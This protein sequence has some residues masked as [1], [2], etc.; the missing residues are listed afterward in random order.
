MTTIRL[1]LAKCT[2][3]LVTAA[4]LAASSAA[5]A[6]EPGWV[7]RVSGAW[8]DPDFS[9]R[10]VDEEQEVRLD[11]DSEIGFAVDVEYRFSNRLGIDVGVTWV[12]LDTTLTVGIPDVISLSFDDDLSFTPITAALNIYLTPSSAVDLYIAPMIAWVQYGDLE[13]ELEG[14]G[15][16]GVAIDDDLAWGAAVGLDVPIGERG[17][18]VSAAASYIDTDLD[19]TEQDEGGRESF[20]FNTIGVK[21]GVG[22]RF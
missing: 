11:V 17:W 12:E 13:Y 5:A 18:M 20:D 22:Y 3:V 7:L 21:V 6:A 1:R 15:R 4:L 16:L 2:W 19:G 10:Q 9:F 8:A 14:V